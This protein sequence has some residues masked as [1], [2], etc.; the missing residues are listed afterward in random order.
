[1]QSI[2][3]AQ[4]SC[5]F[6]DCETRQIASILGRNCADILS[7][8]RLSTRACFWETVTAGPC[9]VELLSGVAA[10]FGDW[11]ATV[12]DTSSRDAPEPEAR[13]FLVRCGGMVRIFIR[14]QLGA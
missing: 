8:C 11:I 13:F 7:S 1:M 10:V 3:R 5:S 14:G 4:L 12:L 9:C 2:L 6:G